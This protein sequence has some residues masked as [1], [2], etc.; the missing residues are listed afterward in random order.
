MDSPT[1]SNYTSSPGNLR[2]YK[3]TSGIVVVCVNHIN[4]KNKYMHE[5]LH[6][7]NVDTGIMMHDGF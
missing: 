5:A 7:A 6:R 2:E 1:I 3:N 4:N